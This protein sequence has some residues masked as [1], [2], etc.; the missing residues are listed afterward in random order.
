MAD[1]QTSS[2]PDR[3]RLTSSTIAVVILVISLLLRLALWIPVASN[4]I[5]AV[6]DEWG[7][8]NHAVGFERIYRS[9]LNGEAPSQSALNQAYGE[10]N[11][12]PLHPLLLAL[13]LL[14]SGGKLAGA[15]LVVV[16]LSA[17]TSAAIYLLTT[18]L[19]TR[20][21]GA[22]AGLVHVFHPTFL[23]FSH[24]LF[25]ETTFLFLLVLSVYWV[26]LLLDAESQR[27]RIIYALLAGAFL[28][29]AGLARPAILPL[30]VLIPVWLVFKLRKARA[31]A[32]VLIVISCLVVLIPWELAV[33]KREGQFFY[34]WANTY[35]VLYI[36]NSPAGVNRQEALKLIDEYAEAHSIHTEDASRALLMAE[37][38]A[39]PIAIVKSAL[40][41][42]P[43]IW[44]MDRFTTRHMLL[45]VYPPLPQALVAA[46]WISLIASHVLFTLF[47]AWGLVV[48]PP[49]RHRYLLIVMVVVMAVPGLAASAMTKYNLPLQAL[50]F[51]AVGHG[52]AYLGSRARNR[53]Y[54][55]LV[56]PAV[57]LLFYGIIKVNPH[58]I[59]MFWTQKSSHYSALMHRVSDL[60]GTPTRFRD[61][62]VFRYG[63]PAL[64]E[65]ISIEAVEQEYNVEPMTST[66]AWQASDKEWE[67]I[68]LDV[69]SRTALTPLALSLSLGDTED[70]I[71]I[72]PVAADSW[73]SWQPT[74]LPQIDYTWLGCTTTRPD[75]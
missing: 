29:L 62:I 71:F 67:Y 9:L 37:V 54:L 44:A 59:G 46:V 56:A 19:S 47:A 33:A 21:A 75:F 6:F 28:A 52:L 68:I 72:E 53:K 51:P 23:A 20:R 10:G 42:V 66:Q 64:K 25:S 24:Y 35:R 58:H 60:A 65:R 3:T 39:D 63:D 31:L 26:V 30:L 17:G 41:K 5:P 27:R 50:L 16:L 34:L 15:R 14:A 2:G 40:G 36:A 7:W 18:K 8:A 69:D 70:A 4:D 32:P 57:L 49:L 12:S 43:T 73:R 22:L 74:G 61:R 45:A 1:A 48:S 13:G 38:A 55:A 11:W